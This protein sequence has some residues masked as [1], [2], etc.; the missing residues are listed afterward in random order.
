MIIVLGDQ[1]WMAGDVR[2]L[3]PFVPDL[4]VQDTGV[5]S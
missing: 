1:L 3:R 2:R 5:S 4:T